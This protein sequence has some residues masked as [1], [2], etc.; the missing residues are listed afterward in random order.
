VLDGDDRG[1][2]ILAVID[3]AAGYFPDPLVL[4]EAVAPDK[5]CMAG[6]LVEDEHHDSPAQPEHVL[7]EVSAVWQLNVSDA[8]SDVRILVD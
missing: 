3:V 2:A 4:D 5:L 8:D 6:W 1:S 7:G